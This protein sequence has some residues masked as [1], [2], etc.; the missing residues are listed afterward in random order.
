MSCLGIG[1]SFFGL[2]ILHCL[3]QDESNGTIIIYIN[4]TQSV[5]IVFRLDEGDVVVEQTFRSKVATI[6][7][8][9]KY[10][11]FTDNNWLIVDDDSPP[12]VASRTILISSPKSDVWKKFGKE[13]TAR[14]M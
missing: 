6:D 4:A 7:Y 11:Y 14:T 12:I 3:F 1:K 2:Y 5:G 10:G 9:N 8:C 13:S